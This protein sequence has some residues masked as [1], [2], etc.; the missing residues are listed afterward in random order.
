MW[1]ARTGRTDFGFESPMLLVSFVFCNGNRPMVEFGPMD[2]LTAIPQCAA[3]SVGC[4]P[5]LSRRQILKLGPLSVLGLSLGGSQGLQAAPSSIGARAKSVI[6]VYCGGGISHHDS[7]DPKPDAPAEVRGE[8]STVSTALPGVFFT[9]LLPRLARQ[10]ARFTLIRSVHHDQTNH[11]VSAYFMQRGYTEPDPSFDGPDKQPR[12]TPN[13]GSQVARLHGSTNGLPPY[14]C[15]PGLSYL[16]QVGYYTAGW[17]GRAYDPFLLKADPN[18]RNF[19]VTRLALDETVPTERIVRRWN[20]QQALDHWTRNHEKAALQSVDDNYLSA[21]QTLTNKRAR[22][23]FAISDEPAA[24]RDAYGR[25]QMGQSC[26]M[27]RR[28]VEAGVPFITIDDFDWDHHSRIFPSLRKQLPVLDTSLSALLTDLSERGLLETTLV[29]VF[30]DFGRTPTIS[31][32]GRDH[33]PGV[34]TVLF[35]GAGVPGGQIVGASDAIGAS[36]TERPVSPKDLAATLYR[37]FGIDPF[38]EYR[39]VEGRPFKVLDEGQAI[40]ELLAAH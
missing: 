21:L 12:S 1:P 4:N 13:I 24:V 31:N 37:F 8:F 26:L 6:M 38:Q 27:A 22:R 40:G 2:D 33:W 3:T 34:F 36:P 29:T 28:L 16:A 18:D 30:T 19:R 17:M 25:T 20:L 10:A 5:I 7:F 39:S 15:V 23:A 35:A 11:G 32:T 9:E 14:M